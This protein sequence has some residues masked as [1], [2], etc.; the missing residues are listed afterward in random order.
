MSRPPLHRTLTSAVDALAPPEGSGLVVTDLELD[1]PLELTVARGRDGRP[2][3]CGGA[4]HTRWVSGVL[5]A[6]HLAHLHIGE[7]D[8]PST[9]VERD[10]A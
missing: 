3:V 7:L 4:P 1:L 2:V 9:R 5:P 10:G 6:V 8:P